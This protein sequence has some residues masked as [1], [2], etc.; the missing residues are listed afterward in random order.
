MNCEIFVGSLMS[1][2]KF[3]IT[4]FGSSEAAI[5]DEVTDVS[6]NATKLFRLVPGEDLVHV[7]VSWQFF[8]LE[9]SREIISRDW[10]GLPSEFLVDI[11]LWLESQLEW[12]VTLVF[13]FFTSFVIF[14]TV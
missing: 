6:F 14:S 2:E 10:R 1:E 9:N 8:N 4:E 7:C 11:C 12:E 3:L 5:Q 13:G